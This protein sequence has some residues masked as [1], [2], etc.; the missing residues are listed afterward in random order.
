MVKAPCKG[1]EE[2]HQGCHSSCPRYAE[3]KILHEVEKAQIQ[4]EKD[5]YGSLYDSRSRQVMKALK[6]RR[7]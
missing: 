1:C 7:G 3:Y 4:K 6:K 2:R 5:M